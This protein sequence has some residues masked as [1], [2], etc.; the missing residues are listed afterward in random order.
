MTEELTYRKAEKADLPRI[1][2]F[3]KEFWGEHETGRSSGPE[4]YEWKT[5]QN[6][7][8]PG[9]M[10]LAED[11]TTVVGM[12]SMV[13]KR[14]RI[15]GK[16]AA[17]AETGDTFTHPGY[18][19]RG[20]FTGL[21]A[22]AKREQGI[23]TR[24]DYIFGLPNEVSLLGYERKLDYSQIPVNV[25]GLALL[26]N[27]AP[28]LKTK[29]PALLAAVLAPAVKLYYQTVFRMSTGGVKNAVVVRLEPAFPEDIETVWRHVMS[30][31]DAAVIRDRDF[32]T[33]RYV[34]SPDKYR[35]YLA[36]NRNGEITGY[37][38][39]KFHGGNLPTGYLCDFLTREDDPRI[40]RSL[41]AEAVTDFK[42]DKVALVTAYGVAGGFYDRLLRRAGFI[43][44]ARQVIISYNNELG[45][46]VLS[47][48]CRWHFTMGDSDH[49]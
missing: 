7:F 17:G 26:L 13:P 48:N 43:R 47:G 21:F 27:P 4:Y 18:Q 5:L 24:L 32:L 8:M 15:L 38:V 11:G 12:K 40:F 14:M 31:Y 44:R 3:R 39:T 36:R 41:L 23:D 30:S 42:K 33:W 29:L 22:A 45:R 1:S 35:I 25:R 46:R 34:N 6:P 10:Y 16:E 9:E 20:I 37:M 28:V 19:R 2:R 49:V